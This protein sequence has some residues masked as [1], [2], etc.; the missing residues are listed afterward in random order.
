MRMPLLCLTQFPWE[1]E[2]PRLRRLMARAAA[3]FAVLYVEPPQPAAVAAP[4]AVMRRTPEGVRVL[5]VLVPAGLAAGAAWNALGPTLARLAGPGGAVAWCDDPAAADLVGRLRPRLAVY[6][7]VADPAS[8]PA[9][10]E[11]EAELFARADAVFTAGWG[12][13]EAK[14]LQHH[15]V[16]AFAVAADRAHFGRRGRPPV[17]LAALRGV[18]VGVMGAPGARF[19]AELLAAVA[20]AR[21]DWHL[22][23][24]DDAPGLPDLPNLRRPGRPAYAELPAWLGALDLV[25]KPL[26]WRGG[27]GPAATAQ[28]LAAGVPVVATPLPDIQRPFGERGLVEIAASPEATLAAAERLLAAPAD[29]ALWLARVEAWFAESA[30]ERQW[31]DM[32]GALLD[33]LAWR[34]DAPAVPPDW[35]DG[36]EVRAQA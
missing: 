26:A 28:A 27:G 29:R 13:Y 9:L 5:R 19:D 10:R 31:E 24:L 35:R 30:W 8:D 3:D 33:L 14:R 21:P 17:A 2:P 36:A 7:C 6:D 12:L 32:R 11:A 16:Y 25:W 18:R 15:E 22:C 4:R 1:A 20:A 34:G 23:L